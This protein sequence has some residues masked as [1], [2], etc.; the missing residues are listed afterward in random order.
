MIWLKDRLIRNIV[1]SA[2]GL[3]LLAGAYFWVQSI[4]DKKS[5]TSATPT[6]A[7][8]AQNTEIYKYETEEIKEVYIKNANDEYTIEKYKENVTAKDE[9]GNDKTEGKNKWR[10]KEYKDIEYSS[11]KLENAVYDFASIS[12]KRSIEDTANLVQYGLN[13]PQAKFTVY[14]ND[15]SSRTMNLGNMVVGGEGYFIQDASSGKVYTI[16]TYK[17]DT[18]LKKR[19]DYRDT[20]LAEADVK[21]IKTFK[22]SNKNGLIANI[23]A[24]NENEK[25]KFSMLTAFVM[26]EPRYESVN[27]DYFSK[28]IENIG[29]IT[30]AS[31]VED[32][33]KNLSVYGLDNPSVTIEISDGTKG[34]KIKYGSRTDDNKVY[35][36]L[37]GK[38]YVFTQDIA[39]YE[40]LSKADTLSLLEKFAHIINIDKITN[41]IAEGQG[42]KFDLAISGEGDSSA[43]TV[44]GVSADES[45]F[46]KAY[47]EIIGVSSNGF[48]QTKVNGTPEYTITFVYKDGSTLV[49]NYINYDE[50]NYALDKNGNMEYIILKKNLSGMMDALEKFAADPGKKPD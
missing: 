44:N 31:F 39:M 49:N 26:T 8:A 27:A 43:Y 10:I 30:A 13:N 25:E 23:R 18:I 6:P 32:Y 20:S 3:G 24:L 17:A 15:G 1:L 45:A 33:P 41:V 46:K 38:N 36:M 50:R 5:E 35:A 28:L 40:T 19:N 16:D 48:A 42:K 4:P 21:S 14:L 2:V 9:N 47:Q 34:Y 22:L 7:A 29:T 12:V 11:I 37:E